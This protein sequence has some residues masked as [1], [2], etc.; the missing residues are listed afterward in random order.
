MIF[1]LLEGRNVYKIIKILGKEIKILINKV[2]TT[3]YFI[4]KFHAI[5][6]P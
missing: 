6:R 1:P 5:E 4:I 2:F 3:K